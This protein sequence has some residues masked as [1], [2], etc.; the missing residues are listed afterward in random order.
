[1]I[2]PNNY[3]PQRELNMQLDVIKR[4]DMFI[5]GGTLPPD[6]EPVRVGNYNLDILWRMDIIAEMI[7]NGGGGGG[8]SYT[9]TN[10]VFDCYGGTIALTDRYDI[11][12]MK[13]LGGMGLDMILADSV[14]NKIGT[15]NIIIQNFQSYDL[16]VK[17]PNNA[18]KIIYQNGNTMTI[19]A[20]KIAEL[21]L[22]TISAVADPMNPVNIDY[23][24]LSLFHIGE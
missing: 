18:G 11:I 3:D 17:I 1:M 7:R 22:Q 21:S 9:P 6:Y 12:Y 15:V 5:N 13:Y 2:D 10:T 4:M 8:G 16:E 14:L 24:T 19:P 20:G 23:I